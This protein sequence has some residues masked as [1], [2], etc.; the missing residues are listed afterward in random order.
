MV[1]EPS[2]YLSIHY[3]LGI[4]FIISNI[5]N[6]RSV[7]WLAS[8]DKTSEAER[9]ITFAQLHIG[10]GKSDWDPAHDCP[11]ALFSIAGD[12]DSQQQCGPL[13]Q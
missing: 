5:H 10:W 6:V 8:S 7:V 3:V 12:A 13:E 4:V 1:R 11:D 9:V 2:Y